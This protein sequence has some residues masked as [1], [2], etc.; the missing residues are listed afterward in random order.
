MERLNRTHEVCEAFTMADLW[1][2]LTD[3]HN[4]GALSLIGGAIAA[5]CGAVWTLLTF[6][7]RGSKA[8]PTEAAAESGPSI[9]RGDVNTAVAPQTGVSVVIAN[10]LSGWPL[11]AL[12]LGLAGL[13]VTALALGGDRNTAS[14][15]SVVIDGPASDSSITVSPPAKD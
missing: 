10:G 7:H 9:P 2:F 13:A 11:V 6:R 3:E 1:D 4:R 14:N 12:F 8:E 15:G 5:L